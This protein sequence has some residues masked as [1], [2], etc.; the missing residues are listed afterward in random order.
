MC[1]NVFLYFVS[2]STWW[3]CVETLVFFSFETLYNIHNHT[4]SRWMKLTAIYKN[5]FNV[6]KIRFL[7]WFVFNVNMLRKGETV[8]LFF[9]ILNLIRV[10]DFQVQ[11]FSTL[12]DRKKTIDVWNNRPSF[13][14]FFHLLVVAQRVFDLQNV[15]WFKYFKFKSTCGLT[16]NI[17]R[18]AKN[19]RGEQ[20][21]TFR[22][23][24]S[25][26]SVWLRGRSRNYSNSGGKQMGR[27]NKTI[28]IRWDTVHSFFLFSFS[29]V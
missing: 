23:P 5:F 24:Q 26:A 27:K 13:S 21:T 12:G 22:P 14:W 17:I 10:D 11:S 8:V 1:L 20:T 29:T 19:K 18:L 9:K 15:F 16:S 7:F 6:F 3:P 4:M 28:S 2:C 25:P